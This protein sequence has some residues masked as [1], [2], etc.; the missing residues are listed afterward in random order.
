MT[1]IIKCGTCGNEIKDFFADCEVC[2]AKENAPKELP[3][4][5]ILFPKEKE[6]REKKEN[7]QKRRENKK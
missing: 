4:M 2:L 7:E 5:E 6:M 3:E 1:S